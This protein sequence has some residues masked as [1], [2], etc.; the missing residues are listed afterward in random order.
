MGRQGAGHLTLQHV[1]I[2]LPL[3]ELMLLRTGK[4]HWVWSPYALSNYRK[5]VPKQ[6][7]TQI[8]GCGFAKLRVFFR[9]MWYK[10]DI[11]HAMTTATRF[12]S[13]LDLVPC[14][15]RQGLYKRLESLRCTSLQ[16]FGSFPFFFVGNIETNHTLP[17]SH[18][19]RNNLLR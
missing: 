10:I 9:D 15:H 17:P 2:F 19:S 1:A 6:I 7:N 8:T 13:Y 18:K 3:V 16:V 14:F 4:A 11:F 5:E 12:I